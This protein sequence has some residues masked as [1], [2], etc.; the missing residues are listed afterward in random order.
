MT[1]TDELLT[2]DEV[3][4]LLKCTRRQVLELTRH[5]AQ[6]RSKHPLPVFKLNAKMLR[7]RRSDFVTWLEKTIAAQ[8]KPTE[9]H[10][11]VAPKPRLAPQRKHVAFIVATAVLEHALEELR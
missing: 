3:A 8:R 11:S 5:R 1:G 4:A 6:V 10:A 2:L 9:V 7:V